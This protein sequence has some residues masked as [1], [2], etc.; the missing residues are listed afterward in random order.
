MQI[1]DEISNVKYEIDSCVRGA[2]TNCHTFA[3]LGHYLKDL[4]GELDGFAESLIYY[5][6]TNESMDE[7][8]TESASGEENVRK[9]LALFKEEDEALTVESLQSIVEE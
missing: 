2:H 4:A 9:L 3:E 1:L 7:S 5:D 6:S 8:L